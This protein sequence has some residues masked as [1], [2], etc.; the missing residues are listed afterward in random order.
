VTETLNMSEVD[1]YHVGGTLHIVINNQLGFTA[2][3]DESRSSDYCTDFAKALSAPIF[4]VN[5]E[6]VEE[7][8]W[9]AKVALEYR[10]KFSTD[11]VLDLYCYRKYGHNEGDDPSFTQ[12]LLY[13]EIKNKKPISTIYSE[14]LIGRNEI[15][16]EQITDYKNSYQ[17]H[18]DKEAEAAGAATPIGEVCETIGRFKLPTPETGVSLDKLS[19]I[20]RSLITYPNKFTIHPKLEKILTKRVE[21]LENNQEI[22]WGFAEG[23]SFGS[24][25]LEGKNVRLSGQDCG[26][27]TFSQ[28]HLLLTSYDGSGRY[29]PLDNLGEGTGRFEVINSTLSEAGVLGF[30]FGY[31]SFAANDLIVWEAQ[32]GDFANGAQVIIDQFISSS[33]QKWNQLSGVVLMLPHGYEGQGPEHSSARLERFLQLCAEGNMV[34]CYPSNAAQHFHLLRTQGKLELKRPLIIMTPKSLLRS[35]QAASSVDDLV[36][37]RFNPVIL[38]KYGN[39]GETTLVFTSGKIFYDIDKALNDNKSLNAAVFRMEQLYPF[40][41][42]AL[43]EQLKDL[44]WSAAY[45]IQEEPQNMGAW[46]Y[47]QPYLEKILEDVVV[48]IGRNPSASTATGSGKAHA[49]EQQSIIDALMSELS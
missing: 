15:T 5:C 47:I 7:C 46:T 6:D 28:R 24:L 40:P 2:D 42:P 35:P 17:E 12:P 11:V 48:Y 8:C 13:E 9:A 29:M 33:E 43:L 1:G 45:W 14:T 44:N 23:L 41:E 30:E 10:M 31:A 18:F 19:L 25:I 36:K 21:T 26:R 27:G 4:H 3:P 32:F 49:F 38:N 34:V 20:A 16:N 39:E 37:G 22:D